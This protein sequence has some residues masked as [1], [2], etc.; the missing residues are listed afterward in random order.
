MFV[1]EE[2]DRQVLEN[3]QEHIIDKGGD[4]LFASINPEGIVGTGAL[5]LAAPGVIELTK[6]GVTSAVQGR[7][8]GEHLLLALIERAQAMGAED[9]F[10]LTNSACAPAIHLYEKCGFLHSKD[11]M[12]EF[13][14]MYER[15]DVAMR[16][17]AEALTSAARNI[18]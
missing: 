14:H 7:K 10:L 8:L 12:E 1:L 2:R 5:K 4:I 16:F 13:G 6:M 18:A 11:V 9:L 15:C 3:P 17:G